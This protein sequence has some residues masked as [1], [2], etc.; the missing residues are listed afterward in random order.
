[1]T[2]TEKRQALKDLMQWIHEAGYYSAASQDHFNG[3]E[4]SHVEE[5]FDN[6]IEFNKEFIERR[7]SQI[8]N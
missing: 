6:H 3:P 7:I 1:M 2:P 8:L 4:R 5:D